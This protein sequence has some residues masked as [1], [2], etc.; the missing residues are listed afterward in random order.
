M[1]QE[2]E[3][4]QQI[5]RLSSSLNA[6]RNLVMSSKPVM[7]ARMVRDLLHCIAAAPERFKSHDGL[8]NAGATPCCNTSKPN[9]CGLKGATAGINLIPIATFLPLCSYSGPPSLA[10]TSDQNRTYRFMVKFRLCLLSA[11]GP[12]HPGGHLCWRDQQQRRGVGQGLCTH[13][14]R[15]THA[16]QGAARRRHR[17]AV[18][19]ACVRL[20]RPAGL[21][22]TQ[23]RSS[24]VQHR[25]AVALCNTGAQQPCATQVCRPARHRCAYLC[26][27]TGS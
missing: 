10:H 26:R 23:A 1:H 20:C 27:P 18:A 6:C 19:G 9:A 5:A 11:Q 25:R 16:G 3:F 17:C 2:H 4:D 15:R 14:V 7:H 8:R 24:L 21:W 13:G 12:A 22:E